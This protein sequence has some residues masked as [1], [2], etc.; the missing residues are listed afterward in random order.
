MVATIAQIHAHCCLASVLCVPVAVHI[1]RGEAQP[2]EF[3]YRIDR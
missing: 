2:V 3:P 1:Y